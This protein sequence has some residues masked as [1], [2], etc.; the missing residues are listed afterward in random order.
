MLRDRIRKLVCDFPVQDSYFLWQAFHR[1][2]ADGPDASLP[3]YLA[4]ENF[5]AIDARAGRV[6]ALNQSLTDHLTARPQAALD[7]YVLL[8]AQD[9]MTDAQ[10]AALWAQI[11]RTARP[12]AG[13]V[14]H[15]WGCR[16]SAGPGACRAAYALAL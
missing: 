8:D 3:P 7:A 11:T 1:G 2:Y 4:S 14:P 15:R 12:G 6:S 16:R 5:D 10:L 13:L 9:W